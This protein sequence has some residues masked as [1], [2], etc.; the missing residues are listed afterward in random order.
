MDPV[1]AVGSFGGATNFGFLDELD[2]T[3]GLINLDEE[4]AEEDEG[5]V[6][7]VVAAA[8]DELLDEVAVAAADDRFFPFFASL[9]S[10]ANM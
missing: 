1:A 10:F 4:D 9:A 7:G 3:F 6:E 5:K 2:S 8:V